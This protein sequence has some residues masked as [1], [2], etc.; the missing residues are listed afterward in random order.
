MV[1]VEKPSA[2]TKHL[3][4]LST[5]L[6]L[7]VT[8]L[9]DYFRGHCSAVGFPAGVPQWSCLSHLRL[10]R[11][12]LHSVLYNMLYTVY[13]ELGKM[14]SH[15]KVKETEHVIYLRSVVIILLF[16]VHTCFKIHFYEVHELWQDFLTSYQGRVKWWA[17][18]GIAQRDHL[19]IQ[20]KL[21]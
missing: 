20:W 16:I 2:L 8:V 12:P 18:V 17:G 21:L 13:K 3:H 4:L 19:P 15:N 14:V 11:T 10:T 5:L 6:F 9:H 7:L 1:V